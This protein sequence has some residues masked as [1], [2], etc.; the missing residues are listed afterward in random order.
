MVG[1]V[2][3]TLRPCDKLRNPI[4]GEF[5]ATSATT[6]PADA[7]V[8]ESIQNSLDARHDS[9]LPVRVLIRVAE[10]A[11]ASQQEIDNLFHGAW[12]HF[13]AEGNGL[14]D[15]K[16]RR[17]DACAFLLFEDFNTTGL[18]GDPTAADAPGER[19]NFYNFF[20]AE[21]VSGKAG[22]DRGRW[23]VGKFVFPRSSRTSTHFAITVRQDDGRCLMMGAVTLKGH[24]IAG[25]E[26]LFTPDALYGRESENGFVLPV[27]DSD[28]IQ[29]IANLFEVQPRQEPGTSVVV[30]FIRPEEFAFEELVSAAV[31]NYFVPILEGQLEVVIRCQGREVA[32]CEDTLEA[33]LEHL[34]KLADGL[35]P[36]IHLAQY[37]VS[38][39]DDERVVLRMPDPSRSAKWSDELVPPD[40]LDLLRDKLARR[41]VVSVRVPVTV[42]SKSDGNASSWFDIHLQPE[43]NGDGRPVFVREGIIVSGVRDRQV[44]EICSLVVVNDPP[45]AKALGDSEN[46]AHTEWQKDGSNF[47]GRYTYGPGLI[48]FVQYGVSSLLRMVNSAS[49][50]PD[51]S[52]TIDFFSVETDE[53][54]KDSADSRKTGSKSGN[55]SDQPKPEV[56]PRLPR[57]NI[58]HS[59][60]GFSVDA[61]ARPPDV[62]FMLEICCAYENGTGN[63]IRKWNRED[64]IFG[65]DGLPMILTGGVKQFSARENR[66]LLYVTDH[67]FH[68]SVDGFDTNRDLYVRAEVKRSVHGDSQD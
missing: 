13:E 33:E 52:L 8:R 9:D 49:E 23:G 11:E 65:L 54:L 62:P 12:E 68:V 63:P 66:L 37:A 43:R 30:P 20:R 39:T 46:P 24:R 6:G 67:D 5:F 42:R 60:T 21:G 17:G 59:G 7:L 57:L 36:L 40:V 27:E 53:D 56:E 26:G 16:P 34:P 25:Q 10:S 61:G 28:R 22:S 29:C 1:W 14:S 15:P 51:P 35:L 32:L 47:K 19:N 4:Q 55:T 3:N 38:I 64:F 45:L 41:E 48:D 44:R 2:F 50:E 58:R 18:T 31:G